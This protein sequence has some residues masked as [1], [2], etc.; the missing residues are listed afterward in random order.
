MKKIVKYTRGK[1]YMFPNG[2][3]A[4]PDRILQDFPAIET[5][6]Y[7]LV[8]DEHEELFAELYNLN[9]MRDMYKVDPELDE[10]GAI[11]ALQE[12]INAPLPEP[13][14]ADDPLAMALSALAEA[15]DNLN[16]LLCRQLDKV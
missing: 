16:V 15:I 1:T 14:Q 2:E 11:D 9:Q 5:F 7:A 3:L 12:I 4:T 6:A 13:K 10:A 8:T